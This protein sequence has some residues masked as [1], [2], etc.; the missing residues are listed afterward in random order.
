MIEG[1]TFV[2]I[3]FTF[4]LP[5]VMVATYLDGCCCW[6]KIEGADDPSLEP[7]VGFVLR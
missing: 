4:N 2:L 6:V 3:S 1:V 7:C 5:I